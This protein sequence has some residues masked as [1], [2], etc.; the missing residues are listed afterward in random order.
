[1][2]LTTL[3]APKLWQYLRRLQA[4]QS[5]MYVNHL[6]V[7]GAAGEYASLT[8][9]LLAAEMGQNFDPGIVAGITSGLGE[10][11][12]ARPGFELW[13]LGRFV[14]SKPQ[15]AARVAKMSA[16]EI[17]AALAAPP[18]ADWKG[19]AKRFREFIDEY[20]Y[21]GMS[22]ADP[23]VPGWAED[24]TFVLSVIRTNAAAADDR[25]P[26]RH[27]DAAVTAREKYEAGIAAQL[28]PAAAVVVETG[29]CSRTP[30]RSPAS[31][32]SP[33][34]WRSAAPPRSSATARP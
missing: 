28:R 5:K 7:S 15:L 17:D 1:M 9:K 24:H 8:S 22:E 31:T 23:S 25:D 4:A 29:G 12:S 30:P 18:D 27:A 2:D 20:G 19:F 32:A 10:I 33:P 13:R 14:R 21:R 16:A 6:G 34:S 26:R 3:S 11:E